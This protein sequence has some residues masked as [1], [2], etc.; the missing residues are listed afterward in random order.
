M[1]NMPTPT[2]PPKPPTGI[3]D[4]PPPTP[5]KPVQVPPIPEIPDD[6][7]NNPKPSDRSVFPYNP[8]YD[9]TTVQYP[10][11]TPIPDPDGPLN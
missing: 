5:P 4:P 6:E 1:R 10:P 9:E 8:Y 7:D 2:P 3:F 11:G